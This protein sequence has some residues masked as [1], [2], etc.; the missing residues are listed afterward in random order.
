MTVPAPGAKRP[1]SA[2]APL[3]N[4]AFL[5]LWIANLL[6]N[7]GGWMQTTGAA[8]EM[9]SL[10]SEPIYV[11]ALAAAGTLPMFLF[12]F[13]AGIL[14]DRFE[15][16]RY[17]ILCQWWMMG[18]AAVLAVLAFL[19]QLSAWNLLVL[20]F[21]MGLGNAMNAP[22]WHA[23]V[24]EIVSGPLLRPA[25]ALNSAGFNL[26][27]TIGPVIG[28]MLLG[29]VGVFLL[30]FINSVTYIGVIFAMQAWKRPPEAHAE[31]RREGFFEAARAGIAYVRNSA[32]LQAVF[33]RGLCF[34]VPGIAM[35]TLL[36]VIGRFALKLDEFS[37][38][39]LYAAFGAGAV[40]GAMMMPALNRL[41]GSDRANIWAM[42]LH[43]LST[44]V[45]AL[46][47]K[48]LIFGLCITIAGGCWIMVIANNGAAVQ[49][50]L[51]N[52]MRA[53]GMAVHQMVFFGA[54]VVGSLL[55]GKIADQWGVKASLILSALS[56]I[57]LTMVAASIRLPRSSMRRL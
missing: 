5:G 31:Q 40:A 51:P 12:C 32:E 11:A 46:E 43:A 45:A 3:A 44:L 29:L 36:P 1:P 27:R 15:R 38:G 48:P 9:T 34:F 53:R 26:A 49:M 54:M 6:S 55:W 47:M 23:V 24:P 30:F 16:R 10:T 35:G 33:A 25:I 8:W 57:P 14:A 17:I 2:F 22:A 42:G 18:V 41:L 21:L 19:G 28:Q 7:V 13:F 4:R 52:F 37:F 50:I 20:S 56:L 39:I